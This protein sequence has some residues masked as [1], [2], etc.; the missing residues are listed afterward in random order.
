VPPGQAWHRRC[1]PG[2]VRYPSGPP[3]IAILLGCA[4]GC[5][6]PIAPLQGAAVISMACAIAAWC[7]CRRAPAAFAAS[8]LAGFGL[9]GMLL[10]STASFRATHSQLRAALAAELGP[11]AVGDAPSDP[12]SVIGRLEAD[13]APSETGVRLAVRIT[14]IEVGGRCRD[15]DGGV[16][17][18]V[19]GEAAP[20]VVDSW[21]R[22]R[23]I[24]GPA[25]LRR[26]ARDLDPG[27]PDQERALARRGTTLV[28][29]VKSALL[30]RV[31]SRGSIPGEAASE[32]RAR[33]RRTLDASV[34][35]FSPRSAAIVRA[36][37][38]GDRAGLDE[39]TERRLQEAGTYHV[40]AISG[41]NIAILAGMLVWIAHLA[42]L[43]PTPSCAAVALVLIGYAFLVG[44]GAS[45]VRATR[46]AVIYLA[47][48]AVDHR[49]RPM[50]AAAASAG[51]GAALDPLVLFDA[52]AW[53][54][55]GATI[56][57]LA[58]TP[59][60]LL[61]LRR[62]PRLLAAPAGLFAASC[63]A[64]I[65]LFP[66]SAS[67]FNRITVAG[68]LL[69]FAAIPLMT[70]VQVGGM[71]VVGTAALAPLV[72]PAAAWITHAAAWGLVESARFVDVAPWLVSRLPAPHPGV[73]ALYYGGWIAWFAATHAA[74]SRPSL[75][76]RMRSVRRVALVAA[77]GA[78]AWIVTAPATWSE[79]RSDLEVTF[80]DVGQGAATLV[81]FP[82]GQAML[83][84]SGGSAGG[85]FDIGRRVVEPA[86]WASGV[87][88][89][90]DF[91]AT[92]G[93]ADHVGGAA[94]VAADLRPSEVW[95]GVHVPPEP[96]LQQLQVIEARHGGTW[97]A[98][99]RGD[100]VWFG[101]VQVVVLHPPLPEWE[102][103][104]VRNDDSVVVDVRMG[105]VSVVLTG[106]VEGAGEADLARL[107]QPAGIRVLQAPHHGSATSS[108]WPL[109][110]AAAPVL[111]VI[112]AGRGNR[113]GHPHRAVLDRYRAAGAQV[114]R[115]DVDGAITLRTDGRT[116]TVTTFTGRV[117]RLRPP[118]GPARVPPV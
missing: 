74:A 49:S 97:R 56:A 62:V 102:R 85:R 50:N 35:R 89:L 48:R 5:A 92:H 1:S 38:L 3:A 60:L 8:A 107:L 90:T 113:F 10:A 67:V 9:C 26:P 52:A 30:I 54:T 69:N 46:M 22:G 44:G 53:L 101:A 42:G 100:S 7:W 66:V 59:L 87:R 71:V 47:S 80:L 65:A 36:I 15:A 77:I 88:R 17:L 43:R 33:I 115:T 55:Y 103:Q 16:T 12:V 27:V 23:T 57:I 14:S 68:L 106:D 45:V 72:T 83:I 114:L 118:S 78:A 75:V 63:A 91:V 24:Q 21:R 111:A 64:E 96:M 108:S 25:Q 13:A 81:R 29:T 51:I 86:I 39:Q 99:Q 84:D 2:R 28:G 11:R 116:A 98:V 4:A 40:L 79:Q 105:A 18:T 32:A 95:E 112:S 104:R 110:H 58:G 41:G 82:S 61:R 109:L 70:V 37:L 94:S 31:V 20:P 73:A 117:I 19:V 34:G 93:D 6:Q 76:R